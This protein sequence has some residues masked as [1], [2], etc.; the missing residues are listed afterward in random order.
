MNKRKTN[1]VEVPR[2]IEPIKLDSAT[3]LEL[4]SAPSPGNDAD[5]VLNSMRA[6]A[7]SAITGY[8]FKM[9]RAFE[10]LSSECGMP[11][12]DLA[13]MSYGEVACSIARVCCDRAVCPACPDPADGSPSSRTYPFHARGLMR[14]FLEPLVQTALAC[15]GDKSC[16]MPSQ[17]EDLPCASRPSDQG[18]CLRLSAAAVQQDYFR[19]HLVAQKRIN[20]EGR[21]MWAF[22]FDWRAYREAVARITGREDELD[23]VL[24]P[25]DL[26]IPSDTLSFLEAVRQL[27]YATEDWMHVPLDFDEEILRCKADSFADELLSDCSDYAEDAYG[28]GTVRAYDALYLLLVQPYALIHMG[29][30]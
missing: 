20:P 12:D 10:S 2:K 30:L 13:A 26:V 14:R 15:F 16:L 5:F 29:K 25:F 7:Q 21:L 6:I 8:F 9:A 18:G 3:R 4:L 22:S 11:S 17:W 19:D 23:A 1:P 27:A 28:M 24:E